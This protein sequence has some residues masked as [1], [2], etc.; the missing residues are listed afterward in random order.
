MKEYPAII[1]AILYFITGM[2][3]LAMALK[4]LTAKKFLPF[5]EKASGTAWEHLDTGIQTVIITMLR[6]TGLGFLVVFLVLTVLPIANFSARNN[7]LKY[8]I[9]LLSFIFCSGLFIF[10][11]DLYRKTGA[12]T[13]WKGSLAAGVIILAGF[14]LSLFV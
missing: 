13:P 14:I 8:F 6:I 10:N 9:P 12:G 11:Y 7:F 2:I 5:H 4:C 3:C 1:S